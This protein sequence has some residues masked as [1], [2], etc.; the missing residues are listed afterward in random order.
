LPALESLPRFFGSP[1]S[2]PAPETRR[3]K[4]AAFFYPA[5]FCERIWLKTIPIFRYYFIEKSLSFC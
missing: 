4:K 3:Q 5:L 1:G 2:K